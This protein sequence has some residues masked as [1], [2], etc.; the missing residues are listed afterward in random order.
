M[1]A[2]QWWLVGLC[3]VC[4]TARSEPLIP[5]EPRIVAQPSVSQP[6]APPDPSDGVVYICPMD[7]DVRSHQ[8]GTCRRCGMALVSGIP[9]PVEFHLD[10]NTIPGIP[11]PARTAVLQFTIHDPWK[12]RLV[13]HFN[14]VH[15]KLFHTFVVSEDL[16]F[17]EHGHPR[18]VADGVFQYPIRFP[19][20]GMY[21]VLGDY[22]PE[23]ATPQLTSETVFVPGSSPSAGVE[24]QRDYSS[25]QSEN[26]RVSFETV[27]DQPVA[28]ART[29]LRFSIDAE[30]GL[31]RYLGAWGHMLGVS[32][33]LIDMMHEHPF[34]AD[35]GPN[36]EF[37]VVFP[38]PGAYRLWVQFQSDDVVN[39][40]HFDVPVGPAPPPE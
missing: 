14:V 18:L 33:D 23:G 12:D 28:T 16:Q 3:G 20:A 8:A 30:H 5:A 9:D 6:A 22:Y 19:K 11:S 40:V 37:E 27:P 38:R 39:T 10:L 31:Q 32:Q 4:L 24:L 35:G 25:K 34:L 36:M 1:G 2:R 17:F 15:E 29:Q 26:M 13:N 7:P 21:R